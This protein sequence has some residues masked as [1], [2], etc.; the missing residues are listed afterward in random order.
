[1]KVAKMLVVTILVLLFAVS[2]S[3]DCP[4]MFSSID[5]GDHSDYAVREISR[6]MEVQPSGYGKE[7][8]GFNV[9]WFTDGGVSCLASFTNK[10][11][12]YWIGLITTTTNVETVSFMFESSLVDLQEAGAT[13]LDEKIAP[14]FFRIEF[15]CGSSI[16]SIQVDRKYDYDKEVFVHTFMY[17]VG[18]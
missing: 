2:A 13:L 4:K 17:S 5:M 14:Y 1:M 7:E 8:N 6:K 12:L 10:G 18:Q 15:Q 11:R 9:Y 16:H 3:A